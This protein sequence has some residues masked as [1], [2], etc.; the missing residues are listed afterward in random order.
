MQ[1]PKD[2]ALP[3]FRNLSFVELEDFVNMSSV[4][5][6]DYEV[7]FMNQVQEINKIFADVGNNDSKVIKRKENIFSCK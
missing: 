3:E 5:I 2:V 4:M 1:S 7:Q 6:K